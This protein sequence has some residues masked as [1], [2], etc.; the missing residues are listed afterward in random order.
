MS[1]SVVA[2]AVLG[3][4]LAPIYPLLMHDTPRRFGHAA[5][6][7][8]VGYQIAAASSAIAIVPGWS[9]CWPGTPRRC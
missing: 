9:G 7:H 6:R 2:I 5:A 3:L 4:A 1:V 8:M